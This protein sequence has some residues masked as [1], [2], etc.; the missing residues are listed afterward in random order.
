MRSRVCGRCETTYSFNELTPIARVKCP[1]CGS[2]Q[3][4]VVAAPP[5]KVEPQAPMKPAAPS[6]TGEFEELLARISDDPSRPL[7]E[8]VVLSDMLLER[9]DPRGTLMTLQLDDERSKKRDPLRTSRISTLIDANRTKWIPPG[10][11]TPIFERGFLRKVAWQGT[12]D[13]KHAGWRTVTSLRHALP[14]AHTPSYFDF[15]RPNL[16]ELTGVPSV[17]VRELATATL[18]ALEALELD[19][20]RRYA[21]SQ[22][23]A[24]LPDEYGDLPWAEPGNVLVLPFNAV[25]TN[26][27]ARAVPRFPKLKRVRIIGPLDWQ[28]LSPIINAVAGIEV[29]RVMCDARLSVLR[30]LITRFAPKLR[31]EVEV[32]F[33]GHSGVLD[34]KTATI[35]V[36]AGTS[37]LTEFLR[38]LSLKHGEVIRPAK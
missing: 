36:P 16:R 7:D 28:V 11:T 9:D 8:F 19:P 27:L 20:F 10:V 26:E 2:N 3:E 22:E 34:V 13:P 12:T 37:G 24:V 18:P 33:A 5:P 15:A 25:P 4:F 35:N 1:R 21:Q 38:E 29:L 32:Y 30:E 6:P 17:G 23:E 31:L 14:F